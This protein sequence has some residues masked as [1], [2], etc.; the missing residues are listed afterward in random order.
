MEIRTLRYFVEIAHQRS[1]TLAAERL[2]VTQP[3]LS[4]QIAELEEE[5]GQVLFDRSTRRVTLTEKGLYLL[6]QAESILALLDRTKKEAMSKSELMG[7]LVICAA[8]TPSFDI[9]AEV[10]H[11]FLTI[12]PSVQYRFISANSQDTADR[13]RTGLADFGLMMLPSDLDG[14][15]Y[16]EI[17]RLNQ[18]GV[19][20]RRDGCFKGR[21]RI[22]AEDLKDIP[23]FFS[24]QPFENR[25]AGW[26]GHPF[27]ELNII[28]RYNL[29]YNVSRI[30]RMGGQHALCLDGIIGE[31][32]ELMFLPL[33]PAFQVGCVIAWPR[34]RAKRLVTEVFLESLRKKIIEENRRLV[35]S[36]EEKQD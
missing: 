10:I 25:F 15:E 32:D 2:F 6:R 22:H 5:L 33:E 1:F 12:H 3:T 28:G 9:V 27:A 31:D 11:E 8:E 19:L 30:V 36:S 14:F 26:L 29:L 16:L 13:L 21:T 17:P 20:T 4:R 34:V 18:W 24:R 23:L 7:E 35:L